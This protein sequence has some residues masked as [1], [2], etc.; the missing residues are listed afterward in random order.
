MLPKKLVVASIFCLLI[1]TLSIVFRPVPKPSPENTVKT[2]GTIEEVFE[3][4]ESGVVFK[5]E[6]DD[7]IYYIDEGIRNEASFTSLKAELPGKAVEIHYIKYWTL[8]D[9]LNKLKRIAKVDVNHT[10]LFTETK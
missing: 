6:G 1:I 2:Y 3:A 7:R 9:P 8:I 10:T 4:G 5:L